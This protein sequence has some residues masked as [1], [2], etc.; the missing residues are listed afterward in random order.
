MAVVAILACAFDLYTVHFV[1]V[2]YYTGLTAH[3][4]SGFVASFHPLATLRGIGLSGVFARL[5]V[6]KPAALAEPVLIALWMGYLC[7][8]SGLLAYSFAIAKEG[9]AFQ[10]KQQLARAQTV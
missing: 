6:N 1:S 8:T 2:P 9:F 4:P 3:L 7:A 5:A 10:P